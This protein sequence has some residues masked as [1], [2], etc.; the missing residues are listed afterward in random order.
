MYRA[1]ALYEGLAVLKKGK[2]FHDNKPYPSTT[3][4]YMLNCIE[5]LLQRSY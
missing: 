1:I 4:T 2:D 5:Y 3:C